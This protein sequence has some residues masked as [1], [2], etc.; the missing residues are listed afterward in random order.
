M[1]PQTSISQLL[2]ITSKVY[3]RDRAKEV[4]KKKENS[5]KMLLLT[6][7]LSSLPAQGYLSQESVTRL[8]SEMPKEEFL[9]RRPLG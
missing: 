2:I 5:Q 4:K 7:S 9:T 8:A 1:E 6:V 3:N